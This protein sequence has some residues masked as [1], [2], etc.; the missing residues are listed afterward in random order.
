MIVWKT[1]R[2][3]IIVVMAE[4]TRGLE[5]HS[6][7][8]MGNIIY[9]MFRLYGEDDAVYCVS[10]NRVMFGRRAQLISHYPICAKNSYYKPSDTMVFK[11]MPCKMMAKSIDGWNAK[12]SKIVC[13][14]QRTVILFYLWT[15]W[16]VVYDVK[17]FTP[18]VDQDNKDTMV[19]SNFAKSQSATYNN[20]VG[21]FSLLCQ[22]QETAD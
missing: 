7:P 4:T 13:Q 3:V 10:C 8:T 5:Y 16:N 21:G 22:L 2:W 15:N 9:H 19:V 14:T 6:R 18:S 20:R 17:C 11:C 12:S 1:L